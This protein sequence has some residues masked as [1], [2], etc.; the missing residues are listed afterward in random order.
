M[1]TVHQEH[2]PVLT[3]GHI[4]LGLLAAALALAA[5]YLWLT[6]E[7]APLPAPVAPPAAVSRQP[8]PTLTPT[9][10]VVARAARPSRPAELA[11]LPPPA[12][13][14]AAAPVP[15]Q[16]APTDPQVAADAAAVGMTTRVRPPESA[17]SP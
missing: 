15:S 1:A 9:P 5:A 4:F 17:P 10:K 2:Q 14:A 16:A 7:S 12:P 11:T 13:A 8:P 3:P 6:D